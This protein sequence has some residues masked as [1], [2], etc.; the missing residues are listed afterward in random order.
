MTGRLGQYSSAMSVSARISRFIICAIHWKGKTCSNN[1][2]I[3]RWYES[4][5]DIVYSLINRTSACK[6]QMLGVTHV[7]GPKKTMSSACKYDQQNC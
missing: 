7:C 2:H 6:E 5:Q 4:I 1:P 3:D